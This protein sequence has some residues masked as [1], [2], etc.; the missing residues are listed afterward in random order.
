MHISLQHSSE[1]PTATFN[2]IIGPPLSLHPINLSQSFHPSS[3]TYI[4]IFGIMK[5]STFLDSVLWSHLGE[6]FPCHLLI[7]TDG[8]C[9]S[10]EKFS[11][12]CS[13]HPCT[14]EWAERAPHNLQLFRFSLQHLLM[15]WRPRE[16]VIL[17]DSRGT[18]LRL[19]GENP[20]N[21]LGRDSVYA[22][23][24]KT[25]AGHFLWNW[26]LLTATYF[27]FVFC[28]ACHAAYSMWSM[29]HF[30]HCF[31]HHDLYSSL[32]C[33]AIRW[34]AACLEWISLFFHS[35]SLH[36]FAWDVGNALTIYFSCVTSL[37]FTAVMIIQP[38]L[39][40]NK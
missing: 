9:R 25:S 11:N 2:N 39:S 10:Y 26:W 5:K 13:Y 22:I 30:L 1:K 15:L 31:V 16:M 36:I 7:Y 21:Y 3:Q 34:W 27:H 24:L 19:P 8:P 37:P 12:C 38:T 29:I 6:A 18:L 35:I 20:A 28:L 17:T 23:G 4:E 32:P 14:L 33:C 40:I